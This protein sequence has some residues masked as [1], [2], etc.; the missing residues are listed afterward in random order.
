MFQPDPDKRSSALNLLKEMHEI[1]EPLVQA[2]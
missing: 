2:N 1:I